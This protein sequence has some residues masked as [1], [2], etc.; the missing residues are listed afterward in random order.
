MS[1][2]CES[3]EQEFLE[4]N[5]FKMYLSRRSAQTSPPSRPIIN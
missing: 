4:P 3:K 1:M 5:K 2:R